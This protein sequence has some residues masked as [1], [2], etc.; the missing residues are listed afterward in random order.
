ME[1]IKHKVLKISVST[2]HGSSGDGPLSGLTSFCR[3]T[4]A[5]SGLQLA[6][7]GEPRQLQQPWLQWAAVSCWVARYQWG[8][9]P[10]DKL[11]VRARGEKGG[12]KRGGGGAQIQGHPPGP[13]LPPGTGYWQN[14]LEAT[15]Y[16][17]QTFFQSIFNWA[18]AI[19]LLKS[20]WFWIRVASFFVLLS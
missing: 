16:H 12:E 15:K 6:Q 5:C 13:G 1:L 18:R 4:A 8:P 20:E 17:S 7:C 11:R 9:S 2:K 3:G 10:I 19:S 14:L